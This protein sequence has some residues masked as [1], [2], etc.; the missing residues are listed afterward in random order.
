[1]PTLFQADQ[2]MPTLFQADQS[3]VYKK[4]DQVCEQTNILESTYSYRSGLCTILNVMANK[5]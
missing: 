5:V 3:N 1:M 2:I 4:N